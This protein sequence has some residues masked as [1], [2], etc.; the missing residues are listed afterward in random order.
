MVGSAKYRMATGS[1]M[2]RCV[3]LWVV[4]LAQSGLAGC[5]IH[6]LP[7]DVTRVSTY[8]IAQQIRCEAARA[9]KELAPVYSQS[10]IGYEFEFHITEKNNASA[11]A[12]LTHPFLKAGNN[13]SLAL[14]AG[15]NKERDAV[16]NF[17]IVDSFDDARRSD[18]SRETLQKNW[19]YPIAGDIGVY[20]VVATFV[21]LQAAENPQGGEM[22]TFADKLTFTTNLS[23]GVAPTLTLN[24]FPG[25]TRLTSASANLS[26]SRKDI[27][28]VTIVLA[29]GSRQTRARTTGSRLRNAPGAIP[30]TTNSLLSTTIIQ[31]QVSTE[32]RV[33]LELD[34]QRL[35]TLQNRVT[36]QIVGP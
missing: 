25:R 12:T 28:T 19:V 4:A 31:T 30:T 27:H 35:L 17:K 11:G 18:C 2:R 24:A 13:F 10:V 34:R 29:A 3:M 7:D 22:F 8:D 1:V 5:S 23:G 33:L 15:A 16:R 26:A 14:S 21:Q 9:I 20:E 6:P 32:Q 36:N